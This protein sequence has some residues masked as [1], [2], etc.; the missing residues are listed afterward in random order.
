MAADAAVPY[1]M[2]LEPRYLEKPWG[3][4]R[5]EEVFG[6][7]LPEGLKI[8]ESWELFDRPAGSSRIRNG[9]LK[10][11]TLSEL[12]GGRE[13]PL[14]LKILDVEERLSVQV[15]PDEGMARVHGT[16]PKTEAWVILQVQPGARVWR[17]LRPGATREELR[18]ALARGS[19][20]AE[21]LHSFEPSPGDVVVMPAGTVHA[22]AGGILFA[23]IQQSS[24]TTYR[25]WDWGREATRT[26]HVEEGLQALR[27]PPPGPDRAQPREVEEDG[28]LRRVLL[29]STP[30]FEAEHV[31]AAGTVTFSTGSEEEEEEEEADDRWHAVLFLS[32]AGT[33]RA[34]HRRA[35]PAPFGPG[36]TVLLPAGHEH[37]EIEPRAGMVVQALAFRESGGV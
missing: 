29:A 2:L 37:Y 35:E 32:G 18:E 6:R 4:R 27:A 30:W 36:D 26:L 5:M 12:R 15:H 33:V 23:E 20:V 25:L 19:G 17:G 31:T 3:G 34:F 22:A 9:P 14:L 8:G 1:P 24:E 21:L 16:D 10:G 11:R 7:P 13:I 28:N